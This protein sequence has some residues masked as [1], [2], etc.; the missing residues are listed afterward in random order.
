MNTP[1]AWR[2]DAKCFGQDIALYETANLP[3]AQARRPAARARCAG[4]RVIPDCAQDA[5][6]HWQHTRGHIRAGYAIPNSETGR[7]E[8]RKAIA[9]IAERRAVS[10]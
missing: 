1:Y 5:F 3:G 9:S 7:T 2:K 4:C 10:A 8:A 6:D